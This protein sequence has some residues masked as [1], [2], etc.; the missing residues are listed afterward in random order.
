MPTPF[1]NTLRSLN[2][3][4]FH[5]SLIG[6]GVALVLLI[7]WGSWFFLAR[8]TIY[9][10]STSALVASDGFVIADFPMAKPGRIRR[11]QAA[12]LFPVLDGAKQA[13][14]VPAVVI[15]IIRSP[16]VE[17]ARV[18]LFPVHDR[19]LSEVLPAGQK[20]RVEIEVEYVSP[21]VLVLRTS[22]LLV[23]TPGVALSPQPQRGR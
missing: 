22:G 20:V 7:A 21:A 11:G 10:V 12:W 6:L 8:M 4:R 3:D 17:P 5:A 19:D 18:R 13:G 2:A 23:D 1:T 16:S 14:S 9:E 15:D